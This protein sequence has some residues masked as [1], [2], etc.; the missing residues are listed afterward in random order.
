MDKKEK[1]STTIYLL[2]L[3]PIKKEEEYG[4]K[5][6]IIFKDENSKIIFENKIENNE[7]YSHIN[8]IQYIF[9]NPKKKTI[10]LEFIIENKKRKK[11]NI[12]LNSIINIKTLEGFVLFMI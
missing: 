1:K 4:E 7:F 9:K 11:K 5:N 8:I 2:I 3:Y 12:K 6:E 10:I